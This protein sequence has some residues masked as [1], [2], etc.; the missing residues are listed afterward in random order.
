M[1]KGEELEW[2][3]QNF[4]ISQEFHCLDHVLDAVK[5]SFNNTGRKELCLNGPRVIKLV[6][7]KPI[8]NIF[9]F[10]RLDV[11]WDILGKHPTVYI[12]IPRI[13]NENAYYEIH[14]NRLQIFDSLKEAKN[15]RREF[16]K[17]SR[18]ERSEKENQLSSMGFSKTYEILEKCSTFISIR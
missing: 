13:Y 3:I 2:L 15:L 8:R 12:M 10:L 14:K 18:K 5:F 17:L 7:S 4:V 16:M 11:K 1:S 6:Y 9:I